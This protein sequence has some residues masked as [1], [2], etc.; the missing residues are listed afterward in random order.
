MWLRA[1]VGPPQSL[2]HHGRPCPAPPPSVQRP[3]LPSSH[4]DLFSGT[5]GSCRFLFAM[6]S[7]PEAHA[8]GGEGGSGEGWAAPRGRAG[9]E[10]SDCT[11]VGL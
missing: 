7:G 6:S 2:V 11:V 3:Q 10:R 9:G 8:D 1:G 5:W 4:R